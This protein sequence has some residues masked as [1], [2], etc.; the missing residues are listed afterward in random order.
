MHHTC[1]AADVVGVAVSVYEIVERDDGVNAGA[2]RQTMNNHARRASM[3]YTGDERRQQ[4]QSINADEELVDERHRV[5]LPVD[6][7]P[8]WLLLTHGALL[9]AIVNGINAAFQL[10]SFQ[11][12]RI[13]K[14]SPF[15]VGADLDQLHRFARTRHKSPGIRAIMQ[16]YICNRNR[17]E[18][19]ASVPSYFRDFYHPADRRFLGLHRHENHWFCPDCLKAVREIEGAVQ[20]LAP[21][22]P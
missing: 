21:G 13:E 10:G 19:Y 7:G 14:D 8:A 15:A 6:I 18:Q 20:I 2:R 4:Q 11:F 16:V 5:Q 3:R 9:V 17:L 12:S 1:E 22:R